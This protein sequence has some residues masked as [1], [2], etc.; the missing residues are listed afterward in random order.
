MK[1]KPLNAIELD[2]PVASRVSRLREILVGIFRA[3]FAN[4]LQ[5]FAGTGVR[6]GLQA[7]Y[8]LILANTLSLHDMGV[9]ASTSSTGIMIGCFSGLGFSSFAFRAAAGKR[10]SLGGYLAVFY[11]SWLI[12]LPLCFVAALPVF[13]LLF[14]TSISLTAFVVIILVEAGTWRIVEM[15][16]QVNNGLGRYASAS[17]VISL[18]TALRAAGAVTFLASGKHDIETW[19]AVYVIFNIAAM[20]LAVAA[21]Q[22]RIRLR[23]SPALFIGRLRDALLFSVA[24]CAFIS[25]NE[26]DKVVMLSLADQRTVGIYAIASRIIDFTSVPIRTFYV[27]YSRKLI[28]ERRALNQIRRSLSVEV[29]IAL[30]STVAFAAL[31]TI[32]SLWPNLLGHNVASAVPLLA[33]LLA[34]PAF[35]N[36]LEYHS[37]LFFAYQQMTVRAVLAT[38]QVALKAAALAL[39]LICLGNIAEWGVWLNAI[40]IGLYALSAVIVYSLVFGSKDK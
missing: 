16:H 33:V 18:G 12:S 20:V 26:I 32:L 25:Q 37:E 36:L 14:T 38:S 13:Y 35:K 40:Y 4:Y 1:I 11:V 21:Y 19:A 2:I 39:L 10:R 28:L 9:F 8:F 17:L 22:P 24:Y 15:I 6:L 29:A 7:V 5:V 31:L 3:Q 27:L 23:W 30:T 34:V